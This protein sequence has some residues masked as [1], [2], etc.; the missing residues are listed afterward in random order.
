MRLDARAR[1]D[2]AILGSKFRKLDG[3][4]ILSTVVC[5]MMWF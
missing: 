4:V 3:E 5:I 2:V 1:Q